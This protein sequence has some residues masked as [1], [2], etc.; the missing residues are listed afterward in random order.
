VIIEGTIQYSDY[1]GYGRAVQYAGSHDEADLYQSKVIAIDAVAFFG[2]Q[3]KQFQPQQIQRELNK[4]YVGFGLLDAHDDD[5]NDREK[6]GNEEEKEVEESEEKKGGKKKNKKGKKQKR[7]PIATGSWGCGA[8]GGHHQL[9]GM[10]PYPP[11]DCMTHPIP[12]AI[13]Q[14]MAAAEAERDVLYCVWQQD[15]KHIT[16]PDLAKVHK[17]LVENNITVGKGLKCTHTHTPFMSLRLTST[18]V[19]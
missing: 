10:V 4:A 15:K 8:F 19:K 17:I 16:A 14:L 13:I 9:K 18:K 12:L 6:K 7:L 1:K 3:E 11:F 2:K 5:H